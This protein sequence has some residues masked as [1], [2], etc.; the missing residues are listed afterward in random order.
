MMTRKEKK[1]FCFNEVPILPTYKKEEE[2]GTLI[3]SSVLKLAVLKNL[4]QSK[5][6]INE[7]QVEAWG[8]K[9]VQTSPN[10]LQLRPK[11]SL[12]KISCWL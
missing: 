5:L 4:K 2:P 6:L 1:I 7:I 9:L 11:P 10:I 8:K 3:F 12:I